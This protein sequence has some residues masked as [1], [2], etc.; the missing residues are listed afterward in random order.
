MQAQESTENVLLESPK[1]ERLQRQSGVHNLEQLANQV[2]P[3]PSYPSRKPNAATVSQSV[4]NGDQ[5]HSMIAVFTCC[6]VYDYEKYLYS[7][8]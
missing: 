5:L 7:N 4:K 3:G 8:T 6:R 2:T 1:P